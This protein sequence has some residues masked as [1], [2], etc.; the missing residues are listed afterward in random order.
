MLILAL[1]RWVAFFCFFGGLVVLLGD[2]W[3]VSQ[4]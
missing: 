4:W 2:R 1:A 3:G